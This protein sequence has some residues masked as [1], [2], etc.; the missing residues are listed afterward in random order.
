VRFDFESVTFWLFYLYLCLCGESRL[1]V[2]WCA[3]GRC[4]MTGSDEDH[5]RGLETWCGG[6]GMVRHRSGIRWPDDQ[7]VGSCR[8]R[9]A[10]CT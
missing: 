8:V 2:S 6:P 7:E 5:G 4:T 9:S 1:L 3:G 10:P